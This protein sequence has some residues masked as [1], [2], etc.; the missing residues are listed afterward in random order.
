MKNTKQNRIIFEVASWIVGIACVIL[1]HQVCLHFGMSKSGVDAFCFF[2]FIGIVYVIV[3][4]MH[5]LPVFK[6]GIKPDGSSY[7]KKDKAVAVAILI[8][9]GLLLGVI[10]IFAKTMATD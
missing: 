4:G 2:V 3:I 1:L 8:F 7:T 10:Y 6:N 5:L 9:A